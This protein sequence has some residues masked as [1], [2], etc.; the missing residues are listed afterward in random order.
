MKIWSLPFTHSFFM[1]TCKKCICV[2]DVTVPD[3]TK[4]PLEMTL[5][6]EAIMNEIPIEWLRVIGD[7]V[8]KLRF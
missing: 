6:I 8:S 2:P 4:I 1:T 5:Y 7:P 3:M